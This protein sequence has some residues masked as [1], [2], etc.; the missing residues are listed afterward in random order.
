MKEIIKNW[1]KNKYS[2]A[3]FIWYFI[4]IWVF[5][6]SNFYSWK[7]IDSD[8]EL[9]L[10]III[11]CV[12]ILTLYMIRDYVYFHVPKRKKSELRVFIWFST[13]NE[14]EKEKVKDEFIDK[15]AWIAINFNKNFR[16][17]EL[18]TPYIEKIK[19]IQKSKWN[20][21]KYIKKIN[22][23]LKWNLY[24]YWEFKN[25]WSMWQECYIINPWY[26]VFHNFSDD[27][28]R[29]RLQ[30]NINLSSYIS[31][32]NKNS[33]WEEF[34][35]YS[36]SV[37]FTIRY[38]VWITLLSWGYIE[39]GYKHHYPLLNELE[40]VKMP[41]KHFIKRELKSIIYEE[42]SF[43]S[44]LNIM[45]WNLKKGLEFAQIFRRLW[46]DW[47]YFLTEAIYHYKK[48]NIWAA[49]LSLHK[50]RKWASESAKY[51][52]AF[53]YLIE[54]KYDLFLQEYHN[55]KAKIL[56]VKKQWTIGK[57]KE[58]YQQMIHFCT[59]EFK[60]TNNA[61]ILFW[62][63]FLMLEWLGD[64]KKAIKD[65]NNYILRKDI[66]DEIK[67]IALEYISLYKNKGIVF[68]ILRYL[69]LTK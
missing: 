34:P 39:Y 49:M 22:K 1:D 38:L 10:Y 26:C 19:K 43:L 55:I 68:K 28:T 2:P 29:Q 20:I 9:L 5:I 65:F 48:D 14:E 46:Y 63:W 61:D 12:L 53:L 16:I 6:N 32:I 54:K 45:W 64:I 44:Y 59:I 62:R 47:V 58:F 35:I 8:S 11:I 66:D 7:E 60:I 41:N 50:A 21:W 31:K 25:S 56:L 23:S 52:K 69:K 42:A 57:S 17:I 30:L 15:V 51:S 24:L 33:Q 37:F 18:P 27:K 13:K 67:R 40:K 36:E 3:V 4:A